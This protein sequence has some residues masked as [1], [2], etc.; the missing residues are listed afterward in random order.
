LQGAEQWK[1][2]RSIER[3]IGM[4]DVDLCPVAQCSG[5]DPICLKLLLIPAFLLHTSHLLQR[6]VADQFNF[7]QT[8]SAK[9]RSIPID[10]SNGERSME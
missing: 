7:L 8:L 5:V 3:E 4:T 9:I 1:V 10:S 2:E 6:A